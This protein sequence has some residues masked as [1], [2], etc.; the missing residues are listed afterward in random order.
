MPEKNK[1]TIK[2]VK[3]KVL[4]VNESKKV[5]KKVLKVE[6]P[7]L[8]TEREMAADFASKVHK[9]FDRLVKATILFGSQAKN[10]STPSSDIDIIVIVDD[11]TVEWDLELV[12]WYRE[13]LAKLIAANKYPRDL[14]V[15]TLKLTTWWYDL[16]HG[17][18]VV[19]NIIRYGE[20]IIDVGGFFNPLK[21][22]LF[23]GKIHSTPEAVHAALQRSPTHLV[24]SR[25]YVLSA[26]EGVYW[27]MVDAAQAALITIG[28]LPPSPEHITPMLKENFVDRN[29][30]K[31]EYMIWYRDIFNL[32][33]SISH[34]QFGEVR[35]VEIDEWQDKAEKFLS[36]MADIIDKL[37]EAKKR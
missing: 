12:A 11:V 37:I 2:K 13:E 33:K 5:K 14:H 3:K 36:E 17:D 25:R 28:K 18:A 35:G 19:I 10:Q 15:N 29:I 22:L 7:M 32:H 8:R 23:Q 4:E 9:K 20:A 24:R 16:M 34:R 6:K 1:S 27:C 30:L 26:I 31:K 21:A